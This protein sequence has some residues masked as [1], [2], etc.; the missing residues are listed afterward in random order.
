MKLRE[1]RRI[2]RVEALGAYRLGLTFDDGTHK[3]ADLQPWLERQAQSVFAPLRDP[4]V[5]R[6]VTLD[7]VLGTVIWPNDA[8]L[9]PDV[10]YAY[11]DP[12]EVEAQADLC[13]APAKA[14]SS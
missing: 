5:F 7:P 13:P 11:P 10:L 1:L 9:C 4:A 12:V 6:Q 8:D 3:E 2:T 14:I